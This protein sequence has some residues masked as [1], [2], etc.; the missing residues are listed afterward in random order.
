MMA[1]KQAGTC[2]ARVLNKDIQL[3]TFDSLHILNFKTTIFWICKIFLELFLTFHDCEK[4]D[5][6]CFIISAQDY[7]LLTA[8]MIVKQCVCVCV[9]VCVCECECESVCVCERER[10]C[11]CVRARVYIYIYI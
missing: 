7:L 10:V 1:N 9:C 5:V 6:K 11:V 4:R 3:E 8:M 2:T